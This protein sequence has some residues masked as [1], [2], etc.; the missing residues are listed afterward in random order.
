MMRITSPPAT[1]IP[2][3]ALHSGLIDRIFVHLE[4]ELSG[5]TS[6]L[7]QERV[8]RFRERPRY[9][10]VHKLGSEVARS[11]LWHEIEM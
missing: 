2:T 3:V 4:R 5:V 7:V 6:K 11:P 8:N 9:M 1:C 10:H